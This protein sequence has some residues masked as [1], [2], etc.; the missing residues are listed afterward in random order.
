MSSRQMLY[1]LMLKGSISR[2]QFCVAFWPDSSYE[3]VRRNF[4]TILH[5]VRRALG[6]NVIMFQ[7]DIYRI[8]PNLDFWCDAFE[9]EALV[10]EASPLSPRTLEAERLWRRA[11]GLY[12]GDFLPNVDQEW[13]DTHRVLLR[14]RYMEAL[15][16]LGSCARAKRDF[17]EAIVLYKRALQI[18]PYREDVHRILLTTHAEKG[19]RQQVLH[20]YEELVAILERELGIAPSN[21]TQSLLQSLLA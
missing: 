4:H 7:D 20:H 14:D 19:E 15:V 17:S 12:E 2:E 1:Y 11:I 13:V 3:Q 8:N 16:V 9:F 6:D 21:E 10:Q 5:R 18:D